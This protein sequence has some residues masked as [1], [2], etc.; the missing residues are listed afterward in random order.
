LLTER[1]KV[2]ITQGQGGLKETEKINK[3]LKKLLEAVTAKFPL[4]DDEVTALRQRMGE[5][6]LAIHDIEY[7]AVETMQSAVA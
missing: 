5:A 6:V 7:Q 1:E 4:T 3:Q 2:F